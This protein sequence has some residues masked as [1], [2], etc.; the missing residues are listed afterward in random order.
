MDERGGLALLVEEY[1]IELWVEDILS[2]FPT[3]RLGTTSSRGE[4]VIGGS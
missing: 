4:P 3:N 2:L 1:P